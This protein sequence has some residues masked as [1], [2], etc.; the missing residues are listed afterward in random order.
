LSIVNSY[1]SY[2]D[3]YTNGNVVLWSDK[4]VDINGGEYA[5]LQFTGPTVATPEYYGGILA[6]YDTLSGPIEGFTQVYS[7]D[8]T[9][10]LTYSRTT[11]RPNKII[12]ETYNGTNGTT[13]LQTPTGI[14]VSGTGTFAG[15]KYDA[16]YAANFTTR[17]LVDKEYVDTAVAGGGGGGATPSLA[18]TLAIGNSTGTYSINLNNNSITGGATI[19]T[20]TMKIL[21]V[22]AGVSHRNLGLDNTGKV[23]Q[24]GNCAQ[25]VF[26]YSFPNGSDNFDFYND[27]LVRFGWDAPG[28]DLEFYMDTEPAGASD[29]RALATLNYGTQQNTF[30]TTVGVLYDLYAVGVPAGNQLVAIIVAETD[31]TYPMYEVSLYNASSNVTVKITKTKKI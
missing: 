31:N 22:T 19:S 30:V 18:Q 20:H 16:N 24:V 4:T 13:I 14:T 9:T 5:R 15:I 12:T 28:N 7:S 25:E 11:Y 6:S 2:L 27:G 1:G 29:I 17:S 3:F 8:N 23:V 26:V 21:G 10:G